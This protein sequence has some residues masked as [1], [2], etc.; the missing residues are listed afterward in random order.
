MKKIILFLLCVVSCFLV[1]EVNA[2]NTN[3][4]MEE[5]TNIYYAMYNQDFYRSFSYFRYFQDGKRVYCI[6][7]DQK[8]TTNVYEERFEYSEL[9]KEV[10]DK[11]NLIGY[12]G[13]DYP[14]HNTLKYELATQALI[15]EEIK[16]VT[17]EW[18]TERYSYGTKI[19]VSEE[20]REIKRLIQNHRIKPMLTYRSVTGKIGDRVLIFDGNYVLQNYEIVSFDGGQA[21]IDDDGIRLQLIEKVG[22]YKLI[23]KRK[24]YDSNHTT[25]YVAPS[26]QAMMLGRIED[27]YIEIPVEIKSGFVNLK[28]YGVGLDGIKIPLSNVTFELRAAKNMYYHSG[29]N[30]YLKDELVGIYKTNEDGMLEVELPYGEYYF[31]ETETKENYEMTSQFYPFKITDKVSSLEVLNQMKYA[32]LKLLKVDKD[33]NEPLEGVLFSITNLNTMEEI[34]ARTNEEGFVLLDKLPLGTYLIKE[35]ETISGYILSEE[36]KVVELKEYK[37]EAFY[38]FTNEKIPEIPDTDCYDFHN[39]YILLGSLFIFYGFKKH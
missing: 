13:S 32:S 26:S 17:V 9:P 5:N 30:R 21:R 24:K 29:A 2:K 39:F 22:N 7:P 19:D 16:G 6:D 1:S 35:S 28:K 20:E 34:S 23:L 15:W 25:Y 33:T 10:L 3:L 38:T 12:F 36:E 27:E 14:G 4:V 8:V 37:E 11:I 31:V 18:Y